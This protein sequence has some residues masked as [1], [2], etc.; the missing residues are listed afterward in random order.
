MAVDSAGI[1]YIAFDDAREGWYDIYFSK[2]I[3]GGASFLPN[4]RVNDSLPGSV[5][6]TSP[7][8]AVDNNENVYIVWEDERYHFPQCDI[9]FSRSTDGGATFLPDVAASETTTCG[10]R[11]LPSVNVDSRG[12]IHVVWMQANV[13][14]DIM[15]TRSTDGGL[16]F[17]PD[18]IVNDTIAINRPQADP[19]FCVD[20]TGIIYA[21]W[22]DGNAMYPDIHFT[23]STDTSN[24]GFVLPTVKVNNCEPESVRYD[25][26]IAV[27]DSGKVYVMWR[28]ARF[29]QWILDPFFSVGKY[30]AGISEKEKEDS[31]S[32]H[33]KVLVYPNPFN[34]STTIVIEQHSTVDRISKLQFNIYDISGRL[35]KQLRCNKDDNPRSITMH[36]D[37]SNDSGK[38]VKQ[39]IYFLKGRIGR[40]SINRKII[41]LSY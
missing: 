23:L 10:Y 5:G 21:V 14:T 31:K 34:K 29:H 24:S 30:D 18:I 6:Q 26:S 16:T 32:P 19:S 41:K 36:W 25:P 28:D 12:F 13:S 4:V 17:S 22:G 39:G 33:L 8:L 35:V 37:G 3:D 15:Y 20:D 11:L 1:I 7:G 2:S 27:G 9:F 40:D 38:V